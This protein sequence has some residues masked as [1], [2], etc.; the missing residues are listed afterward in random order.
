MFGRYK[1]EYMKRHILFM[2]EQSELW[3]PLLLFVQKYFL[4]WT[5]DPQTDFETASV[6]A[7]ELHDL[8]ENPIYTQPCYIQTLTYVV[9]QCLNRA[10]SGTLEKALLGCKCHCLHILI[11]DINDPFEAENCDSTFE[12]VNMFLPY[13]WKYQNITRSNMDKYRQFVKYVEK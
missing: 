9:Y 4:D 1:E 8:V 12:H 7:N 5:Y 11:N 2:A 3:A 6:F 13:L 10:F